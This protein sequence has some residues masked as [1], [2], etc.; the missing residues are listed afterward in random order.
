MYPFDYLGAGRLGK[1]I[2]I[3]PWKDGTA[4]YVQVA[5]A[6]EA[7]LDRASM[8]S[9][10]RDGFEKIGLRKRAIKLARDIARALPDWGGC[11]DFSISKTM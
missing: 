11:S 2:E 5:G 6:E 9:G 1:P 4:M 7:S 10:R 8:D 3:C